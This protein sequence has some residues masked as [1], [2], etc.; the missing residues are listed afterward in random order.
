MSNPYL[1]SIHTIQ[2]FKNTRTRK[3]GVQQQLRVYME[4]GRENIILQSNMSIKK[5]FR[6]SKE[7]RINYCTDKKANKIFLIYKEIVASCKVI[8]D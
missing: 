6:Q 2:K 3:I 5:I 7:E 1:N 8:Y 4:K